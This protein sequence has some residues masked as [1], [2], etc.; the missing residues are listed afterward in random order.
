M[1]IYE[2]TCRSCHVRFE[3][4]VRG[5]AAAD[6]LVCPACGSKE[7]SKEFST[8]APQMGAAQSESLPVCP[9]SGGCCPTPGKCGLS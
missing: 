5:E 4:L 8:F 6:A 2:Y 7:L 3:K 1:P 9:S